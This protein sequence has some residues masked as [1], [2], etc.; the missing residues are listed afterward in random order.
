MTAADT[1]NE[2][3]TQPA[4]GTSPPGEAFFVDIDGY[5]GP[6]DVLLTLARDQK[7]DLIHVSIL[8]L[9]DQ[10]LAFVAEARRRDL[11]LAA[12]YLVMAAWLA[13]LK[14]RLLLPDLDDEEQPSGEEMAAA[15]AWQLQRLESM[16]EAGENL[17]TRNRL[18]RDF[19]PRGAPEKFTTSFITIFDADLY[20]LMSAYGDIQ[21]RTAPKSMEIEPFTLYTVDQALDRIRRML[22][23][24]PDWESLWA[25]LPD[26]AINENA[27]PIE[28]RSAIAATFT[29]SL[30]LAREGQVNIRQTGPFGP[31]YVSAGERFGQPAEGQPAK[32][33][34]AKGESADDTHD[35][36][37][38]DLTDSES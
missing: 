19:F 37:S 33:Q 24:I 23:S 36:A 21:R 12:D 29:A 31:I 18:G 3:M 30:E 8:E 20:D 22:G 25:F 13:Y 9:A 38:N 14:S 16:R 4:D 27:D 5:A 2:D 1:W 17:I 11:E 6:L 32:G 28:R 34:P 26:E 7:V 10:Y 35:N 15:L